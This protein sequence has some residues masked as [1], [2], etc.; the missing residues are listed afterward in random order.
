MS[1]LN[2]EIVKVPARAD[3]VL[4]K[5][6]AVLLGVRN[7]GLVASNEEFVAWLCGRRT[8]KYIGTDK[9]VQVNLIDFENPK[10]KAYVSYSDKERLQVN[11]TGPYERVLRFLD[12][13]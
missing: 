4:S 2:P 3:E 13:T 1:S 8:I 12:K 9:D 10:S 5:L 11:T 6:R 7:D